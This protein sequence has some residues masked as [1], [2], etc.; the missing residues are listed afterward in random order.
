MKNQKKTPSPKKETTLVDTENKDVQSSVNE[1]PENDL[2]DPE[3]TEEEKKE[4]RGRKPAE[5]SL[6]D[7]QNSVKVAILKC[8]QYADAV[9]QKGKSPDRFQAASRQLNGILRNTLIP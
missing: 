7:V 3:P 2:K 5:L 1:A 6:E 8:N 4:I 9:K